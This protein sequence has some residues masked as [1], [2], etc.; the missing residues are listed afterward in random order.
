MSKAFSDFESK[1]IASA[2]SAGGILLVCAMAG[3]VAVNVQRPN[4]REQ[5]WVEDLD[6]FR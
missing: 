5:L 6:A 1:P 3:R 4:I 2:R